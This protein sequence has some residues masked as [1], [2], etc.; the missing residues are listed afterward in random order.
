MNYM[1]VCLCACV[2]AGVCVFKTTKTFSSTKDLWMFHG[3]N[4]E[5][6]QFGTELKT[7]APTSI[8]WKFSAKMNIAEKKFELDFPPCR[9]PVEL[10]SI[11]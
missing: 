1:C 6:F 4:T 5:L 7:K 9:A 10:V 2:R 11:K 3:I 8:P